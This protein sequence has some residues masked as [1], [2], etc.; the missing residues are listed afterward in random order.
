V[1]LPK[2]EKRTYKRPA[3]FSELG[4]WRDY[5]EHYKRNVIEYDHETLR[6]KEHVSVS[7]VFYRKKGDTKWLYGYSYRSR[8]GG[9]KFLCIGGPLDKTYSVIDYKGEYVPY[10]L[11]SRGSG[12]SCVLLHKSLLPE[13]K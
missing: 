12:P 7:D 4:F 10:N 1:K 6:R 11:S 3:V 9:N 8:S 2:V 5:E 13:G